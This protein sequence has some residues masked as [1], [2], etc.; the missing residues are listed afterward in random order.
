MFLIGAAIVDDAVHIVE[1]VVVWRYLRTKCCVP[2]WERDI[3]DRCRW[4]SLFIPGI[5]EIFVLDDTTDETRCTLFLGFGVAVAYSRISTHRDPLSHALLQYPCDD[6]L[7]GVIAFFTL[8][9]R[10]EYEL[11]V[12]ILS[13]YRIACS[14]SFLEF[15][16][17]DPYHII[18]VGIRFESISIRI[19]EA[20]ETFG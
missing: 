12:G 10:C 7:I 20:F 16:E 17:H 1:I 9:D 11:P 13:L 3:G 6:R 15:F 8:D 4:I 18:G 14:D 5:V 19:E 2:C